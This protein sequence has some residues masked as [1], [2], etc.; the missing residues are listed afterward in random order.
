MISSFLNLPA[1]R[2]HHGFWDTFRAAFNSD[3]I[4]RSSRSRTV[5]WRSNVVAVVG[6]VR[7]LWR[8]EYSKCE[9]EESLHRRQSLRRDLFPKIKRC[10]SIATFLLLTFSCCLA[11]ESEEKITLKW[12]GTAGWEIQLGKTFIFIDPFLTRKDRIMDAEWKTDETEVLKAIKG[13]DYIFAGHSHHDHIGDVP[14]IAKRFGAKV[15]GSRTTANLMLTAGV[16]PSQLVTIGG[17]ESLIAKDFSVQVIESR[18]GWL[19]RNGKRIQPKS[20]EILEPKSGPLLGRD[21]VEG[22]SFLYYFILGK[23]RVLHQSTGNFIEENLAGLQPDMI[24]MAPVQGYDLANVLK[25]LNPKTIIH[26]H[27]DEWQAPFTEGIQESN[28]KRAG[29]FVRE[30]NAVNKKIKVIVPSFLVTYILE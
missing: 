1:S 27:F 11:T 2:F 3:L 15:I 21:F 24:L 8:K 26:H 29:R 30:V 5:T 28:T 17:G 23:H 13:A 22:K 19:L 9:W 12:L 7:S 6:M 25:M 14:F 20:E 18:H 4:L 10:A 16:N